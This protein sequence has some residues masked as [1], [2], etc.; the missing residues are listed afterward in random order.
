MDRESARQQWLTWAA[1]QTGDQLARIRM[2]EAALAAMEAGGGPDSAVAAAMAALK[3][4]P[5][6]APPASRLP[7]WVPAAR[8]DRIMIGVGAAALLIVGV[9]A[10]VSALGVGSTQA[11]VSVKATP[12]EAID[13]ATLAVRGFIPEGKRFV[14]AHRG[15][16]F[17]QDVPIKFLTDAA[18]TARITSK[19]V[20]KKAVDI[21]NKEFRALGLIPAGVDLG[22][23]FTT[24][25][26]NGIIGFYDYNS[27]ELVVRGVDPNTQE[28]VTLV[29]ELTHALQD[30]H[31]RLARLN[32]VQTDEG[33]L[34]FRSLVE[35]DAVR[36]QNE[37]VA[38]LPKAEQ[39]AYNA[40]QAKP[41][42]EISKVPVAL[43]QEFAF[44]YIAGPT[45]VDAIFKAHGQVALDDAFL[46]PPTTS[47]QLIHPQRFLDAQGRA[48]RRPAGRR[49]EA[50]R[51]RHPWRTGRQGGALPGSDPTT[52]S[53]R[54]T[55]ASPPTAGPAT[56]TSHG[57]P[58]ARVACE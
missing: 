49:C 1:G 17:T 3:P 43:L 41:P 16:K 55:L 21:A 11:K 44:P 18:F 36:I 32:T 6:S 54:T 12:T 52:S 42:T 27:K 24:L 26:A 48:P 28:R 46:K 19:P 23:E 38:S 20:D 51:W 45:F 7:S 15:L 4:P 9:V 39:D 40:S 22:K 25:S 50:V 35:G 5:P 56:A 58:P 47:A 10:A 33:S 34:A 2:A 8:S 30:Q 57:T 14:E 53:R 37:Y 13:P 31:F 29:H